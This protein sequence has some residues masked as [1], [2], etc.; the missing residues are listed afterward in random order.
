MRK[1]SMM[2]GALALGVAVA[3]Q[4]ATPAQTV[5]ARQKLKEIGKAMK[6]AGD[7]FKSGNPDAAVIKA[8]ATTIAGYAD[9]LGTWFPGH[10]R[11]SRCKDR[12]QG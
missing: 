11:R 5:E 9:K 12:R 1:I 10:R 6:G 7:S 8:S 3:A 2:I 4:A